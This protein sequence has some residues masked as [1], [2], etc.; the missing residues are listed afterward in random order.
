VNC[1]Q[2]GAA[3]RVGGNEGRDAMEVAMRVLESIGN[4][5]WEGDKSGPAGPLHLPLPRCQLF[6]P[7]RGEAAA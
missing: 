7:S 6:P 4:H 2:T 3:P 5:A 1:V